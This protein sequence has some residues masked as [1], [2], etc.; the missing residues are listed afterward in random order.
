MPILSIQ[1]LAKEKNFKL[2]LGRVPCSAFELLLSLPMGP[3]THKGEAA[4]F[5]ENDKSELY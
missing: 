5:G 1:S 4:K 3:Q 2:N